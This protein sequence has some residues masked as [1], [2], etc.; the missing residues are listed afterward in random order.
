ME[1]KS[2]DSRLSPSVIYYVGFFCS[3]NNDCMSVR[4][5]GGIPAFKKKNKNKCVLKV[6]LWGSVSYLNQRSGDGGC[7]KLCGVS[8]QLPF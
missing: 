2:G 3:H 1:R 5:G 6:S 7:C 4:P 8:V